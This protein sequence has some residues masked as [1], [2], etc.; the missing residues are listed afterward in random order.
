MVLL[1]L[2]NIVIPLP[3][4]FTRLLELDHPSLQFGEVIDGSDCDR[5]FAP[6][7]RPKTAR[8]LLRLPPFAFE[9]D[10]GFGERV[11]PLVEE[12]RLLAEELFPLLDFPL[13][14]MGAVR[15]AAELVLSA[16]DVRFPFFELP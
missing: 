11:V 10:L 8:P 15:H 9:V 12:V 7:T 14:L 4:P 3:H 13:S 2:D 6:R 5:R 1:L 16:D